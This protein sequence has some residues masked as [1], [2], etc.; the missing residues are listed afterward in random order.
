MITPERCN[1]K[2]WYDADLKIV[3]YNKMQATQRLVF[4]ESKIIAKK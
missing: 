4:L 1:I 2:E 3:K